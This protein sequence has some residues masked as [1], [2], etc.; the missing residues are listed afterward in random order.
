MGHME[1]EGV[2]SSDE[3]QIRQLIAAWHA[4]TQAGDIDTILSLMT[5]DVVFLVPGRQPMR[6]AEFEALSRVP[7]GNAPP[8]IR[9]TSKVQEAQVAGDLAFVWT[10]LFVAVTPPGAKAP[11]ERAGHT[12]SVF[13][14]VAGKWLLARDA[15]LLALVQQESA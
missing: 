7:S 11:M 6:K 4:A 8:A 3:E 1:S 14:R 2:V 9:S 13:R 5:D 15:N 12:L 10:E